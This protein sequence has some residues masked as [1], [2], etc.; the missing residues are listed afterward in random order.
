MKFTL[1]W[2]R[3]FLDT[4]ATLDPI[5]ETLTAI[6]L[7]VENVTDHSAAL[8]PFIVAEIVEAVQHP[9]ADKLRVCK[10]NDGGGVRQV[11]CGAPNARA[12]I[13]VALAREGVKIPANGMVIKKS[14]IRGVESNGMLCSGRELGLSEESDGIIELSASATV[15]ESIV[16]A[17]GLGDPVID[18]NVTP[19]R[20]D[21]LGVYGIARDLAAAGMGRLKDDAKRH[22]GKGSSPI[23]MKIETPGCPLFIGCHITGVKNGPS[24]EW[25]QQR[26]KSIGLRPIST[27]VD[28]T[29]F[30]TFAYGRPLHVFDAGKLKGNITVRAARDGEKLKAL[31][32]KEYALSSSM[33]AICDDAGVVGLGGIIGGEATGCDESTTDVFLEAAYFDPASIAHTGRALGIESDARYRFERGVDPAFVKAGAEIAVAMIL[34]LCGGAASALVIA[35]AEPEWKRTIAF[36]MKKVER[37][38]GVN[39]PK[40]RIA[41]TLAALGFDINGNDVTPPSWRA[42][43]LGQAD[44]VEEV[45]RIARYEAIPATALPRTE[46]KAALRPEAKR[47]TLMRKTLAVHGMTEICGWAFV[48]HAQ[49]VQFGGGNEAL[50]LLNPIHADLDTMR[51]SL[52]PGLIA[53]AARNADRGHASLALF[54]IGNVFED[55]TP[56][57][58]KLAAAGIRTAK[59]A[60]RNSFKTEREVDLFDAKADLFALLS[61]AGLNP[62]KLAIDRAVP[63]WYHPTRAGR[64]SLGGKITLGFFGELHPL[65]LSSFGIKHRV[66]AFEAMPDAIPLPRAKGSA[67][68]ALVVSNFQAVERDFAFVADERLQAA[69]VVKAVE[70]AEKQLIQ[71]VNVFDVYAGKGMEPGKKSV[72]IAVTLQATDRTLTDQE[73]E[74]VSQK[75]IAAAKGIGLTLRT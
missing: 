1:S 49:A 57:G 56:K 58:Q 34:E 24:P 60:P 65:A 30:M 25:L 66:V 26:L 59:A 16:G 17:L 12:G 45:L 2:L 50:R 75:I 39:L 69:D 53:A 41:A 67:R 33:I 46:K 72:A 64:I 28:I 9:A 68:P 8:Q 74:A 44:L 22:D 6:G 63:A 4:T 61:A 38:G 51:P 73:I 29:N 32:G 31:D 13:K 18:I 3:D 71:S 54:E 47:A 40:E 20:A 36:D 62:A 43:I 35:G 15:G 55:T 5:T 23:S 21:A 37:L 52:L 19:N 27:L 70:S 48:P 42:D 14:A 10:V 7:E 11:V